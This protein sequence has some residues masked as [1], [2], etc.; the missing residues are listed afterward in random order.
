MERSS[1]EAP[2]RII[3]DRFNGLSQG[4][5]INLGRKVIVEKKPY[6]ED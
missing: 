2:E 6:A 4:R 1:H 5:F 3:Q